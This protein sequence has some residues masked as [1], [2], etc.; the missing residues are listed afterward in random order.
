MLLRSY[1]ANVGLRTDV[2]PNNLRQLIESKQAL[3]S[4]DD[5]NKH[6]C[7]DDDMI[8]SLLHFNG[9]LVSSQPLVSSVIIVNIL[10][11]VPFPLLRSIFVL[12]MTSLSL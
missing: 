9:Q 6:P 4:P 2:L 7:P 12:K 1:Y 8:T 11:A 3:A 5:D 10:I